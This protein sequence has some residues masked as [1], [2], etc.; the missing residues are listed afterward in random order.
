MKIGLLQAGHPADIVHDQQGDY[1]DHFERFLAGQGFDFS[2]YWVVDGDF[3]DSPEDADGWLVTGSKHGAYEDLPWIARL[4]QFIRDVQA[5]NRPLIGV[6]FGHQIIAQALGGK[7]EKV[8]AG[9]AVGPQVYDF[10]DGL[11]MTLNAWHQDQV[12]R[13]PEGAKV[14]AGNDFCPNAAMLIGDRIMTI[15][16]HPEIT[17]SILDLLI[18]HRGK[19]VVPDA[20][21]ADAKAGLNTPMDDTLF[22]AKMAAFFKN[23]Q[24]DG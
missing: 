22:A 15:Q 13:A 17:A 7:V 4:E 11:K 19:G 8:D 2:R 20:L 1:A 3:P 23:G 24:K 6:C 12:T 9:W 10:E 18:S 5:T 16:P 21:L 14:I